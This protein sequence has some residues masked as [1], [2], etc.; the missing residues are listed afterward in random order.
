M[1]AV[2]SLFQ[3]VLFAVMN[4]AILAF[5]GDKLKTDFDIPTLLLPR[6]LIFHFCMCFILGLVFV[7]SLPVRY[8]P[9]HGPIVGPMGTF[10]ATLL[11]IYAAEIV[12]LFSSEYAI[13][14]PLVFAVAYT[15]GQVKAI[16]YS[17]TK[18]G[19]VIV[20][21]MIMF[22][23]VSILVDSEYVDDFANQVATYFDIDVSEMIPETYLMGQGGLFFTPLFVPIFAT[24]ASYGLM[25]SQI[26]LS[27]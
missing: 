7:E 10:L 8:D 21:I 15:Y 2:A 20:A 26:P 6:I 13:L 14:A 16:N 17:P 12:V 11:A 18:F 19:P 25:W 9:V 27:D 5:I 4:T 23:L 1:G 3:G 24:V 22:G